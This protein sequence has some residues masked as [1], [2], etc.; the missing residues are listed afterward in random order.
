MW[1]ATTDADSTVPR[2]WLVDQLQFQDRGVD[3]WLGTVTIDSPIV[4]RDPTVQAWRRR[5]ETERSPVHGAS[6]GVTAHAYVEAGGFPCLA[7]GEDRA[8]VAALEGIGAHLVHDHRVPV[9]T[10]ARRDARAPRGVGHDLAQLE[11]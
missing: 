3:A 7:T 9:L 5:Y 6:M 10:S 4:R 2:R 11:A 8:L 1:L